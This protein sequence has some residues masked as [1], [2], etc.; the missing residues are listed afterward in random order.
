MPDKRGTQKGAP[1]TGINL[2]LAGTSGSS[3]VHRHANVRSARS[4]LPP[5]ELAIKG[6]LTIDKTRDTFL[7]QIRSIRFGQLRH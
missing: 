1:N 7:G 4:H 3:S 6:D 2:P 5:R